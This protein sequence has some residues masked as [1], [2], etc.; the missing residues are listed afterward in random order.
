MLPIGIIAQYA[1]VAS[2]TFSSEL[3]IL[4]KTSPVMIT[5]PWKKVPKGT[6]GGVTTLGLFFGLLGSFLLTFVALW[7]LYLAPPRQIMNGQTVAM[8]TYM[9]LLGSVVDSG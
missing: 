5:A 4:A 1:A 8:I 9:G 7:A 3:G 2:D 6:N